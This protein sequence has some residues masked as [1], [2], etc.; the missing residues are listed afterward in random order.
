[1]IAIIL[2]LC[3]LRLLINIV[4]V[5]IYRFNH[6]V[7]LGKTTNTQTG[8]CLFSEYWLICPIFEKCLI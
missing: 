1:M 7:Q 3:Q 6:G 4:K 5:E 8:L 2:P